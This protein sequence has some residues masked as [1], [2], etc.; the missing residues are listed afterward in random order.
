MANAPKPRPRKVKPG[1]NPRPKMESLERK[2]RKAHS[3]VVLGS[4]QDAPK[5]YVKLRVTGSYAR[6]MK[7]TETLADWDDEE[8]ARYRRRDRKGGWSGASPKVLPSALAELFK[9][10]ILRR[11]DER[12]R[13]H[14]FRAMSELAGVFDDD[15][16][17]PSDKINAAKA[18][19]DRALGKVPEKV[20]VSGGDTP[21]EHTIRSAVHVRPTAEEPK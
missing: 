10:E 18:I 4:R 14:V 17:K 6:L 9:A 2:Q 5:D 21:I 20:E 12:V 15:E 3:D 7:G 8:L 11:A 1:E 13:Q 19:L 16:A